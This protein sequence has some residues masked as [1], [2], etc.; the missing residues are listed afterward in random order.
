[1]SSLKATR[2]A[3]A[4]LAGGLAAAALAGCGSSSS[5][6]T[7]DSTTPVMTVTQTPPSSTSA[8]PTTSSSGSSTGSTGCTTAQL[9]LALGQPDGATSHRYYSLTF[10]NTGSTPCTLD[11]FPGVSFVAGADGHQVGNPA[12][13]DGSSNGSVTLAPNGKATATVGV[14]TTGPYDESTCK[15]A[16]VNGFRVYPPGETHAAFVAS[17]QTT[18]SSTSL[19]M[20]T[21][22]AVKGG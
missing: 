10:T 6:A 11:G 4:V 13:R 9:A 7:T 1:M 19:T 21:I 18:C 17:S 16:P 15:P 12:K 5:T 20:L 8:N 14:T 22:T 2:T 3:C